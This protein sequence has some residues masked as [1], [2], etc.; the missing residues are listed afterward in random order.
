MPFFLS[1]A[2][3]ALRRALFW[4]EQEI[5]P[6][7]LPQDEKAHP[8]R[9]EWWYFVSHLKQAEDSWEQGFTVCFIV[10]KEDFGLGPAAAG[11]VHVVEHAEGKRPL[12]ERAQLM[13]LTYSEPSPPPHLRFDFRPKLLGPGSWEVFSVEGG[14]GIYEL[15]LEGSRGF[16]LRLVNERPAVSLGD[17]GVMRYAGG[18]AMAYY[19]WPHLEARGRF[20]VSDGRAL[21]VSGPAWVD[22][23]WGDVDIRRFRWKYL[24]AH[25]DNGE[26]WV[27]FR[28]LQLETGGLTL[29]GACVGRDGQLRALSPEAIRIDDVDVRGEYASRS[30]VVVASEDLSLNFEPFQEDQEVVSELWGV[31]TFWEGACRIDGVIAGRRV[32][33]IGMTELANVRGA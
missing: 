22:R 1:P 26:K 29:Y 3:K 10:L 16:Q 6:I 17:E 7:R 27:F 4:S 33:G 20:M 14:M 19:S 28:V 15:K 8:H 31:P 25:L 30:K 18:E 32:S 13:R 2:R 23:Q 5:E 21:D 12:I 9:V 11:L 24:T